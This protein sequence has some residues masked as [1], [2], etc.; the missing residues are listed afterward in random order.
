MADASA[1][2]G[3]AKGGGPLLS[4]RDIARYFDVSKPWLA[5]M[6]EGQPRLLLKAVDGVSFDIP[7]GQTLSLVGESCCG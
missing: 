3:N 1:I 7:R 5:R 6:I 2:P 4:V